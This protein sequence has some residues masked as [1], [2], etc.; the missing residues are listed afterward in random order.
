MNDAVSEENPAPALSVRAA[1]W[2]VA[3]QLHPIDGKDLIAEVREALKYASS[4]V[5]AEPFL[6]PNEGDGPLQA[7]A[8]GLL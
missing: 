6:A 1:S 4:P 8:K 7:A 2:M 5:E 3:R